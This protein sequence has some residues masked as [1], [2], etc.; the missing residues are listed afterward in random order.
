MKGDK[1]GGVDATYTGTATTATPDQAQFAPEKAASVE[2]GL[3]GLIL[4]GKVEYALTAYNTTFTNLQTSAFVGTV[5]FVTNV[6]KARTRGVELEAHARPASGLTI[7]GTAN[8]Q[9]AKYISFPNAPCTVA[10]TP[11]PPAAAAPCSQDLSGAPTPFNSKVS[12]SF[13]AG[14]EIPLA[15]YRLAGG[16]TLVYR[17]RY[18]S[19]TNNDPLGEQKG[20][21]TLDLHLDLK[22]SQ[23]WWTVSL[24]G[25]DVT[26]RKYKEYSVAAPLIRGGFNTYLSRGAEV[27]LRFGV[28]L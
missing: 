12:G 8:Y 6:G 21:V 11:L 13:G 27:G 15:A 24:F 17:S 14:Y 28:A 23:G 18:N 26:D 20:L 22:P 4:D 5:L 3:K 16:W 19:S 25:R 1:S 9:G 7:D 10:Q 2:G